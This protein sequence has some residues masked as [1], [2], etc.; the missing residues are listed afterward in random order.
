MAATTTDPLD[1][2]LRSVA[3]QR[4]LR[5]YD[6]AHYR[7]LGGPSR[8]YPARGWTIFPCIEPDAEKWEG[9][10]NRRSC[11]RED[12]RDP[13]PGRLPVLALCCLGDGPCP[14]D[15]VAEPGAPRVA[16]GACD[17]SGRAPTIE[18]DFREIPSADPIPP[19]PSRKSARTVD[20]ER[21]QD[22]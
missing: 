17:S 2:F 13:R 3:T 8:K 9:E 12:L 11:G 5:G 10:A 15:Q 14:L 1:D 4:S 22:E 20:L 19:E 7:M 16:R 18:A 6:G 21:A